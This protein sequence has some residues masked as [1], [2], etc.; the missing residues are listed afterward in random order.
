MQQEEEEFEMIRNL[1]MLETKKHI[2][3]C[4]S[5]LL[6]VIVK[7]RDDALK[8]EPRDKIDAR[9]WIRSSPT[10]TLYSKL[11]GLRPEAVRKALIRMWE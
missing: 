1:T 4:A 8:G 2:D 6:A 3:P 5:L 9:L 10:L 11:I 7:A